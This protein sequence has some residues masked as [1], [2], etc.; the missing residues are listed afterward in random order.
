MPLD[1]LHGIFGNNP[2][3]LTSVLSTASIWVNGA[4]AKNNNG[5]GNAQGFDDR[6]AN[7]IRWDSPNFG[8]F[9][10]GIQYGTQEN[11]RR[12]YSL[13]INGIYK[14]GPFQIG[15]AWEQDKDYRCSPRGAAC[16]TN[17]QAASVAGSWNF[18][19]GTVA[20][21]WDRTK[22][23]GTSSG[24]S[25]NFGSL[26]RDF[27]GV[28]GT[29]NLGPGKL[30]AFFGDAGDWKGNSGSFIASNISGSSSGPSIPQVFRQGNDSGGMQYEVSYTYDLSKRTSVYAGYVRIQ[31]DSR[32]QYTFN[33]NAYP[34]A[35]GGDPQAVVFG[36]IHLF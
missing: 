4:V 19:I 3:Y 6:V 9:T 25:A 30:Y 23:K 20:A 26:K 31:N 22:Y 21:V 8:G 16:D 11:G 34:V 29:F 27:W 28:S 13:G 35:P 12:G 7:S 15:A 32:S 36:M 1:D 2:T 5:T 14:A 33:I 24:T 10:T 18:G 17:D